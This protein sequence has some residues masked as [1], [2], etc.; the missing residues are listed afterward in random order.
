MFFIHYF[1][2]P[3]ETQKCFLLLS[4]INAFKLMLT[5]ILN[6]LQ[7]TSKNKKLIRYNKI[8]LLLVHVNI[9]TKKNQSV[10][11]MFI[12]QGFSEILLNTSPF[13]KQSGVIQ[14]SAKFTISW[15]LFAFIIIFRLS[16]KWLF[17]IFFLFF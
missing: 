15:L 4:C 12:I 5:S 7:T 17:K 3:L 16:A 6:H 9:S 1:R 10:S 8:N 11:P 14:L 2:L 13:F